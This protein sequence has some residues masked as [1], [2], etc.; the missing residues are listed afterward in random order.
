M[1]PE[2]P[3]NL[4]VL[5]VRAEQSGFLCH[6]ERYDPVDPNAGF[7][8]V[9]WNA[10]SRPSGYEGVAGGAAYVEVPPGFEFREYR[11]RT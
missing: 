3:G 11:R 7:L 6:V 5:D 1:S 4:V 2:A 8:R 10:V 9:S